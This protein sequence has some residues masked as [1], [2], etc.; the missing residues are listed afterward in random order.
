MAAAEASI[1]NQTDPRSSLAKPDEEL[2]PEVSP[3]DHDD[4]ETTSNQQDWL[5]YRGR[6][7]RR[8]LILAQR[9]RE[10][11]PGPPPQQEPPNKAHSPS[12]QTSRLTPKKLKPLPPLPPSDIKVVIRPREG[13]N[14]GAWRT[15]QV[16]GAINA[17]CRFSPSER[18][19]LTIRIRQDQN[20]AI[21]STPD[22]S[23][24][25]RAREI[26]GITI[27][28]RQFE[29]Q[30]YVALPDNSCRGVISGISPQ[31]TTDQLMEGLYARETNILFAR[32]M[33]RTNTAIV[34]FEGLSVPRFLCYDG[35][36]Y[37]CYTH[38][39][40]QQV[41]G[42]CLEVGHRVDVCPHP[43]RSRCRTC[44]KPNPSDQPHACKPFC[45]HCSGDHP[46]TDSK[47][48][49]RIRP[50][51]NKRRSNHQPG[52]FKAGSPRQVEADTGPAQATDHDPPGQPKTLPW[53]APDPTPAEAAASAKNP[54][55]RKRT[56]S[57]SS[58]RNRRKELP[59][60][61]PR[62]S[63]DTHTI[64]HTVWE[65]PSP[66]GK[67]ITPA[68]SPTP[69]SW[70]AALSSQELVDQRE[71]VQRARRIGEANGALD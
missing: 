61:S 55:P 49:A 44:G 52:P 21:V 14:L 30:A 60:G 48:P 24:A 47:C 42:A 37:R 34:T 68:P 53:Q 63:N 8:Q 1:S 66:P 59:E 2:A 62:D 33:G 65:C 70:E 56:R 6:R 10:A 32:M 27:D 31:T 35:G 69:T 54:N 3:M 57:R 13:L 15:D 16:V 58:P 5:T 41:C 4:P 19:G 29:V 11:T 12:K 22:E 64:Y 9:E 36:E 18:K 20:L 17:A 26:P 7:A 51:H 50:P 45:I 43:E 38:R 40:K 39:P 46:S 23:V 71:L 28:G 67:G 25:V